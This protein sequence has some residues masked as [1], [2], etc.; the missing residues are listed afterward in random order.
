M[1]FWRKKKTN[2]LEGGI[3]DGDLNL[4]SRLDRD[5]SDLLDNLRGRVEVQDALVDA[6][7]E[8]VPGVGSLS[9]RRLARDDRKLL[10]GQ[11]HRAGHLQLLLHGALLQVRAN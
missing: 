1:I 6:H 7:L 5:R 10:G 4:H 2:S 8:A 11:P 9:A 3:G